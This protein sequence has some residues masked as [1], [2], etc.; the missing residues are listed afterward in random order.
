MWA[1][2]QGRSLACLEQAC[3]LEPRTILRGRFIR[4]PAADNAPMWRPRARQ[5]WLYGST[6]QHPL[7][8]LYK[9]QES[10]AALGVC[11]YW[12]H[13]QRSLRWKNWDET[14]TEHLASALLDGRTRRVEKDEPGNWA[15]RPIKNSTIYRLKVLILSWE[16]KA[17]PVKDFQYNLKLFS[18]LYQ[19]TLKN[20][21]STKKKIKYTSNSFLIHLEVFL[22]LFFYF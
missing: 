17:K 18:N 20:E 14:F 21:L 22:L 5:A 13:E 2:S 7:Q 1:V 11:K 8:G 10:W 9:R 6:L 15:A 19:S 16:M 12:Q 4:E 3:S